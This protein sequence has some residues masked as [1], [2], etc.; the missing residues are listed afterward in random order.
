MGKVYRVGSLY[1]TSYFNTLKEA[2]QHKPGGEE[3]ETF[4]QF[5]AA[6]ECNRLAKD[7]SDAERTIHGLRMLLED[8]VAACPEDLLA[9]SPSGQRANKFVTDN[10]LPPADAADRDGQRSYGV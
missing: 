5:D 2:N 4:D 3:P 6:E 7:V 10:P 9:T 1:G 8:L